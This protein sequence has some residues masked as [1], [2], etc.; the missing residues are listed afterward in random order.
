MRTA[1]LVID[2]QRAL[3]D[4]EPRPLDADAVIRRINGLAAAARAVRSPVIFVQHETADGALVHGGEGWQLERRLE[5]Q[6]DDQRL[7]KTTPDAFQRTG[8]ERLL[9]KVGMTRVVICG[10]ATE[11]CIDTTARRAAGL[12]FDVVLVADA[13]TT[14]D[15]PHATAEQIRLHHNKTLPALTSFGVAIR[16]DL[17][18]SI[19]FAPR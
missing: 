5:V 7:H 8:L 3:F 16:A 19:D 10:Y 18:A 13:H 17:A 6:P 1:L 2:V 9:R 4:P 11:F 14:H 12:G 15:K